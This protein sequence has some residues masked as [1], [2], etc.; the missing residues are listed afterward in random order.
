MDLSII[1]VNWNSCG[2]LEKCL[3]SIYGHVLNIQFEVIV[4]DNASY[5]GCAAMLTKNFPDVRFVQSTEN[6]GFARANNLAFSDSI[7]RT[8]LFLNPDTEVTAGA[9]E[10]MLTVFESRPDAGAVGCRLLNSDLS[11]QITSV[12]AFPTI[13]NEV[14]DYSSLREWFPHSR[15]WGNAVLWEQTPCVREVDCISGACL[16]IRRD[17]F[18]A[19]DRFS[20]GY[21]MY[22]EDRDLCY[23]V[24]QAGYRSYFINTADVI[25]YGGTSSDSR[26]ESSF[27][28]VMRC[29]SLFSFMRWRRG[30]LYA[31]MYRLTMAAAAVGRLAA[32]GTISAF[33]SRR[34]RDTQLRNSLTKWVFIFRWTAGFESWTEG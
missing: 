1:I 10:R 31:G 29:E 20:T 21:F 15:L 16:M 12:Q 11:I 18:K 9:L 32:L 23:K 7:G 22:V 8:L 13:L 28:T 5:D 2:Y 6:L 17:V 26:P 27:E 30:M 19:I 25:H 33:S 34:N 24:R 14:L 3:G 4:I